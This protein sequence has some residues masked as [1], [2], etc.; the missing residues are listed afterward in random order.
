MSSAKLPGALIWQ[1][2]GHLTEEAIVA[3]ADDQDIVPADAAAHAFACEECARRTGEAAL[4]S[5]ALGGTLASAL[6]ED[7]ATVPH[8]Q[9]TTAPLPLWALVF[10]LGFVGVG[11]VPFLM[12]IPAWLPRAAMVLERTV[13]VFAHALVSQLA[14]LGEGTWPRVAVTMISLAV[15]MMSGFAVS[16]LSPHEG[17]AQ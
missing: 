2:G 17:V 15:L 6:A 5:V 13:P 11:A 10:G 4:L 7:P 16:R 3:L 9:R 8:S 1:E 12:G 14:G